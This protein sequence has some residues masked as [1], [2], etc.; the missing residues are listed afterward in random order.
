M[1]GIAPEYPEAHL[2]LG[3]TYLTVNRLDEAAVAYETALRLRPDYA[4]ALHNLGIV[5]ARRGR[6]ERAAACFA[7]VLELEPGHAEAR[8]SLDAARRALENPD[9]PPP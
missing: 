9:G 8:R 1:L 6:F 3:N 2:N 7:R 4:D 5:E